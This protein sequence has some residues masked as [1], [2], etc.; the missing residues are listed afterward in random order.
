MLNS[1]LGFISASLTPHLVKLWRVSCSSNLCSL[2]P[3][4]L[5]IAKLQAS[6]MHPFLLELHNVKLL[7]PRTTYFIVTVPKNYLLTSKNM[8]SCLLSSLLLCIV[9]VQKTICLPAF[10][11][12]ATVQFSSPLSL[13]L[14]NCALCSYSRKSCLTVTLNCIVLSPKPIVL[15]IV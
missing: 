11:N 14:L 9:H 1:N 4:E 5:H 2:F 10:L 7:H 8:K 13:S 15:C 6:S 12:F 3:L